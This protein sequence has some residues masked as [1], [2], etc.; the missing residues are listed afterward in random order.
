MVVRESGDK[1]GREVKILVDLGIIIW[2]EP[3]G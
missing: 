3:I 1:E 2:V